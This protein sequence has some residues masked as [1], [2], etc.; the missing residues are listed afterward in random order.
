MRRH[1]DTS[2]HVARVLEAFLAPFPTEM[3]ALAGTLDGPAVTGPVTAPDPA[4]PTGNP[5]RV[6]FC[7]FHIFFVCN[8][9]LQL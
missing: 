8:N 5:G 4:I 1:V 9:F 7:P 6:F 2:R 3:R